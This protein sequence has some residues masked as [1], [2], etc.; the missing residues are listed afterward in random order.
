[1]ISFKGQKKVSGLQNDEGV[2]VFDDGGLNDL[3]LQFFQKLYMME[4][5]SSMLSTSTNFPYTDD[6]HI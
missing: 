2:W 1:M 6:S 4:D 5:D 3:I